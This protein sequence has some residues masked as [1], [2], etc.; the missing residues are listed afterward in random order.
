MFFRDLRRVKENID[1]ETVEEGNVLKIGEIEER[2]GYLGICE[3]YRFCGSN[4][5]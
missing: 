1:V 5:V 4:I 3:S 2:G